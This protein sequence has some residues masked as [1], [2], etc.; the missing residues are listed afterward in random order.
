MDGIFDVRERQFLAL[1]LSHTSGQFWRFSHKDLILIAPVD[2][3][4][5]LMRLAARLPAYTSISLLLIKPVLGVPNIDYTGPHK[6]V[7]LRT[8]PIAEGSSSSASKWSSCGA[9]PTKIEI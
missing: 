1:P 7:F 3:D 8:F 5:M 9:K 6:R 4:F 2:D